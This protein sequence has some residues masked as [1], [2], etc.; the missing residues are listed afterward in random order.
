M[1]KILSGICIALF[2]SMTFLSCGLDTF[3]VVPQPNVL[4][5]FATETNSD[6]QYNYVK[7]STSENGM[8]SDFDFDGTVIYY[9]IYSSSET[10]NRIHTDIDAVNTESNYEQATNKVRS[11]YQ[12]LKCED[13][14][15]NIQEF[16]VPGTGINKEVEIRLVDNYETDSPISQY[17]SYIKISGVNVYK[18]LRYLI[19][20]ST[21]RTFNF[22][23]RNKTGYS[24]VCATPASGDNDF[25]GGSVSDNGYYYIDLYAVAYGHD[26]TYTQYYSRPAHLGVIKVKPSTPNNW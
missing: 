8:S 24:D 9:K 6:A 15:Q 22:G 19:Q 5:S 13:N 16:I 7:F 11:S 3:Y 20:N 17:E 2:F 23:W 21:K 25:D 14:V 12:I 10:C 1:K 18:P 26:V 4:T